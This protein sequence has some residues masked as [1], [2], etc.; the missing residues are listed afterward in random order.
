MPSTYDR[1]KVA[2]R[3]LVSAAEAIDAKP[4]KAA[5]ARLKKSTNAA[6]EIVEARPGRRWPK[7]A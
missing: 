5:I 7:T 4:T 6:K 3:E 2:L 1:L